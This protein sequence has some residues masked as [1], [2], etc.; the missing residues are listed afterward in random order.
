MKIKT[1]FISLFFI[2]FLVFAQNGALPNAGLTPGNPF[3]FFDKLGEA[4]REFFTFSPESKARLQIEFATERVAEIK[5]VLETK[6]VDAKGL[7]VAEAR[8]REHLGEAADIVIKQKNKGKDI[9]A[10]AKELND[11]F[12]KPKSVLSDSFKIQKKA[13][14][15]K[16]NELEKQLKAAHKASDTAKVE[17][18]AQELGQVKAQLELL[19]LKEEKLEDDLDEEEEKLEDGMDVREEAEEAIR[20]AKKEKEEIIKEAQ[21]EGVT[22]LTNVFT[23]F[24]QLFAQAESVYQAGNYQE[25]ERLAEQAENAIEDIE[26]IIEE[27]KEAKEK[28][29]DGED[30]DEFENLLQTEKEDFENKVEQAKKNLEQLKNSL[31]KEEY[32]AKKKALEKSLQLEK[33]ALEKS[34][35][36][37]KEAEG[38]R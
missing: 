25:T 21:E 20:E 30:R 19:E 2:P 7:E 38:E 18:F 33:E 17:T 26:D 12:E 16:E 3:Y 9:S 31:S 24:D 36:E 5:I 8:L 11:D 4:L 32:E 35:E 28:E 22:L 27:F 34:Q 1:I 23:A 13:L 15:V 6:G 10:L 29:E 37:R 14:E